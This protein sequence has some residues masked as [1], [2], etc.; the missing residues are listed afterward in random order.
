MSESVSLQTPPPK[1]PDTRHWRWGQFH[2]FL[3]IVVILLAYYYGLKY[4]LH[5]LYQSVEIHNSVAKD[6]RAITIIFLQQLFC[7]GLLGGAMHCH[8]FIAKEFNQYHRDKDISNA[9]MAID[10]LGYI[11]QIIGGGLTGVILFFALKTG[12]VVVTSGS[13]AQVTDMPAT[14]TPYAE[15]LI[16]FAG[17]LGTHHVKA[18][19]DKFGQS[20]TGAQGKYGNEKNGKASQDKPK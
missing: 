15:W 6:D 4:F 18:F 9:P 5:L 3:S 7:L 12:L 11:M 16:A 19:L 20:S 10:F 2:F 1:D 14:L 13:T 17:G 8:V